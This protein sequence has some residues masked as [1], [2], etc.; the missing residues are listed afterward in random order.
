MYKQEYIIDEN[1]SELLL[2]EGGEQVMMEWE[3]PYMEAIIN[4]I[5]PTGHV[6]EIGFGCGYSST[7]I[8]NYNPK[9][10]TIIECHPVV[11]K[12]LN[13]WSKQYKNI[14]IV[15]GYWQQQLHN[16]GNF[17]F[18]FFDDYPLEVFDEINDK[19]L[20]QFQLQNNRFEMF[21]DIC[22]DWHMESGAIISGYIEGPKI[23]EKNE[24]FN[25]NIVN[26]PKI[27]YSE[28]IID[29]E[30]PS[31]CKY[32]RGNKALIPILKKI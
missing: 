12:K 10:H 14:N 27:E 15:E 29:I 21:V 13:K 26:N 19:N 23:K 4:K 7:A 6:L 18:I 17:D 9:S 11:I 25:N 1:G 20:F 32:Y 2:R 22:L 28:K 8:Q 16:L 24:K 3:K 5:K 31:N 30:V